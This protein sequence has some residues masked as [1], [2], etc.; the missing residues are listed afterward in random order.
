MVANALTGNDGSE[1][2]SQEEPVIAEE[3]VVAEEPIVIAEPVVEEE[4]APA[5]APVE[6][7]PVVVEPTPEPEQS[8]PEPAPVVDEPVTEPGA[9]EEEASP[10]PEEENN[11]S[12]IYNNSREGDL[13]V[14]DPEP[15][16]IVEPTSASKKTE[17]DESDKKGPRPAPKQNLP[18]T[19]DLVI[20]VDIASLDSAD[21]LRLR[22]FVKN[23]V[24]RLNHDF[25][26]GGCLDELRVGIFEHDSSHANII[27]RGSQYNRFLGD[28]KSC[29]EEDE[30]SD[31]I[32]NDILANFVCLFFQTARLKYF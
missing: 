32:A 27:V 10:E 2:Y 5:P 26:I 15:E 8:D 3:P 30:N 22:D 17:E 7:E 18:E 12:E 11:I 14:A 19:P 29:M 23:V 21:S 24:V 25:K 4:P 31:F 16:A 20:A 13:V 9:V 1:S 6:P 28:R